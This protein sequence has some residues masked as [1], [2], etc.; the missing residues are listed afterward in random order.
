[1]SAKAWFNLFIISV[2]L[3]SGFGVGWGLNGLRLDARAD[4]LAAK[5]AGD[6]VQRS[7]DYI[8]QLGVVL[9][10]KKLLADELAAAD[11]KFT[12]EQRKKQNEIDRLSDCVRTGKCGLRVNA[13][14]PGPAPDGVLP[15]TGPGTGVGL[16]T[17]P[18]LTPDAERDYFALR[19]ALAA[20]YTQLGACVN[21]LGRITGQ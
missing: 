18:R 4:K 20:Q 9:V 10:A 12:D 16:A 21:A 2:L 7:T 14:C 13:T 11:K 17:A 8:A 19:K 1:M 6:A 3:A 15:K 5:V